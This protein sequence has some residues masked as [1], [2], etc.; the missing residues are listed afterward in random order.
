MK[1]FD[2]VTVTNIGI[3]AA[4]LVKS[5]LAQ[6]VYLMYN[7]DKRF[8]TDRQLQGVEYQKEFKF[9]Y[10]EMRGC[11]KPSLFYLNFSIDGIDNNVGYEVKMVN[12]DAPAWLFKMSVIQSSFYYM[13]LNHVSSLKTATFHIKAGNEPKTIY[14]NNYPIDK[15]VL[16]YGSKR[17]EVSM[18]DELFDFYI[19]KLKYLESCIMLNDITKS[20]EMARQWDA[21]FKKKEIDLFFHK[22]TVKELQQPKKKSLKNI[23]KSFFN[24]LK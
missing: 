16:I 10:E 5:S 8:V 2:K 11:Y 20:I 19:N 17:Y 1:S 3:S 7:E 22:I 6:M 23:I 9:E 12:P 15:F 18:C 4:E 24:W 14:L 21:Q 13:L